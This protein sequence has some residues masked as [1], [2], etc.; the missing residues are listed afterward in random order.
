MRGTLLFATSTLTRRGARSVAALS[1]RGLMT[2]LTWVLRGNCNR[3]VPLLHGL[4]PVIKRAA[5]RWRRIFCHE[6]S[7]FLRLL[8]CAAALAGRL[9]RGRRCAT[10]LAGGRLVAIANGFGR[11]RCNRLMPALLDRLETEFAGWFRDA[12]RRLVAVFRHVYLLFTAGEIPATGFRRG[13]SRHLCC[14][15]S[16]AVPR[17]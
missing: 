12:L 13:Q 16:T 7:P 6:V 9:R 10:T 17:R 11:A 1:G 5:G 2:S 8:L 15:A 4:K 14:E 3:L